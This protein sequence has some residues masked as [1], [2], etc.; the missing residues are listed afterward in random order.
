MET[1]IVCPWLILRSLLSGLNGQWPLS[2]LLSILSEDSVTPLG[3]L[4]TKCPRDQTFAY[5]RR[6]EA[7]FSSKGIKK[8][9]REALTAGACLD[10]IMKKLK[11]TKGHAGG[12]G[13][14]FFLI[15]FKE[16]SAFG[17]RR[18]VNI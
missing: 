11:T 17:L 18:K 15:T 7:R 3:P 12:A 6:P 16:S 5:Q 2:D 10:H 14:S 4:F 8:I 13:L 9:Q 1:H